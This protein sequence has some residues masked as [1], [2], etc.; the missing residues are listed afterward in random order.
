VEIPIYNT[1]PKRSLNQAPFDKIS[2]SGTVEV[3][4]VLCIIKR[5]YDKLIRTSSTLKVGE[6]TN[7]KQ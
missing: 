3:V 2:K 7:M 1:S 5:E 4:E 6:I